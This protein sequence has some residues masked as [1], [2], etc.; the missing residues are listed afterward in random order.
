M[1]YQTK[2]SFLPDYNT[3]YARKVGKKNSSVPNKHCIVQHIES[4]E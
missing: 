4:M 3:Q 2:I 1:I